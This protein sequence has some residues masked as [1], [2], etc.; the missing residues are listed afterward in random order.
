MSTFNGIKVNES[1]MPAD[2]VINSIKNCIVA[3]QNVTDIAKTY[4]KDIESDEVAAP[5]QAMNVIKEKMQELTKAII[6]SGEPACQLL[7]DFAKF[8][9]DVIETES[10]A[11]DAAR[12]V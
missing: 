1:I 11:L 3:Y 9:A 6:E 4:L 2:E 10:A 7:H 5:G 12:D 8:L